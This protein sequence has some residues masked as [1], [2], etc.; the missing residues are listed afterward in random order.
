MN[1]QKMN[2]YI[3]YSLIVFF[4]FSGLNAQIQS[5]RV[6]YLAE[7]IYQAD[8]AF[9]TA[10]AMV[11]EN[12]II[13]YV[14]DVKTADSL[15]PTTTKKEFA[16][17]YIYPGFI[18]AHC[19]FLAY[20][21]GLT[22]VD[23]VGSKSEADVIN[24]A[25]KFAKKNKLPWLIGRGWDQNDWAVKNFPNM[26]KLSKAFPTRP[27]CLSRIDGHAVWIN[28]AAVKQL[29]LNPD[30]L[31][32]GGEFVKVNGEFTGICIDN[33]ADWVKSRLPSVPFTA[34]EKAW[35]QA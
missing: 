1:P 33:A 16:G 14:G 8:T 20:S 9:G 25:K 11:V 7:K 30:T 21:K 28:V 17:K 2:R 12:G 26:Q 4:N 6:T 34:W 23:L 27:V 35:K 10:N 5:N 22:E 31:I 3:F 32:F 18:D 29:H 24:R 13:L 15:Y 19:H